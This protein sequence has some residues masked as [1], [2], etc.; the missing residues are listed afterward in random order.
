MQGPMMDFAKIAD[1]ASRLFLEKGYAG[2]GL[3]TVARELQIKAA[4]LYHHCPGGKAELYVRSLR[5][6]LDGYGDRMVAS[7]G[8]SSFPESLHRMVEYTIGRHHVDLRRVIAEDLPHLPTEQQREVGEWLHEALLGPISSEFEMAKE[9]GK[10]RKRLDSALAAA[11]VLAIA[12]NIGGL[13]L[14]GDAATSSESLAAARK[15]V[16]AGVSML[17]AG[18]QP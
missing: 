2:V 13:H 16:R 5:W 11:C 17:L 7:R 18:A 15:M 1:V 9:A 3:R 6:Y 8:K 4:S 10:I 14:I 12:D